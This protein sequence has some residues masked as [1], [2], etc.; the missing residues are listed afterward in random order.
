V[1]STGRFPIV[2]AHDLHS[3]TSS[4]YRRLPFLRSARS[5]DL[6]PLDS[7]TEPT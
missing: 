7:G 2:C 6:L 5:R 1:H 3:I 4:C